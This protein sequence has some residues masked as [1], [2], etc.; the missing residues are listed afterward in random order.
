MMILPQTTVNPHFTTE[1]ILF[2]IACLL[3]HTKG[4]SQDR[5]IYKFKENDYE[6]IHR[7]SGMLSLYLQQNKEDPEEEK[8]G[9]Q[10]QHVYLL[11][12]IL[13]MLLTQSKSKSVAKSTLKIL[14]SYSL[15]LRGLTFWL[16]K[17]S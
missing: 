6:K 13:G 17:Y 9:N 7:L 12:Y 10:G 2:I 3:S 11:V 1:H 5:V 4:V 8:E 16:F 14:K 15:T